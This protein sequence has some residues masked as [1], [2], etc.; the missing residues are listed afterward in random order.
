ML[1]LPLLVQLLFFFLPQLI[2]AAC[3][4]LSLLVLLLLVACNYL[5]GLKYCVLVD[6]SRGHQVIGPAVETALAK[7]ED[8]EEEVN[9]L[10]RS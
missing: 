7:E 2:A 5:P 3:C 1:L 4:I 9:N 10:A 8:K 6:T